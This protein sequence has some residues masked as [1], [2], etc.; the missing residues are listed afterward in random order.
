[1]TFEALLKVYD[2][3]HNGSA[4]VQCLFKH[5][6]T[7]SIVV[8]PLESYTYIP[9]YPSREQW[10]AGGVAGDDVRV[11]VKI[12]VAD[13]VHHSLHLI[14]RGTVLAWTQP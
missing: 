10:L 11:H 1:M 14:P 13:Q 5:T 6:N 4:A 12:E 9:E 7:V 2:T 8:Y 3:T